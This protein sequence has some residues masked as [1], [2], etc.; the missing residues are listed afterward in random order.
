M[1]KSKMITILLALAI[2]LGVSAFPFGAALAADPIKAVVNGK[3]VE[4]PDVQPYIDNNGR[5]QVPLRFVAESLGGDV[6]W[7]AESKTV[8]IDR[9]RIHVELTI[10]ENEFT[11]LGGT[12]IMDTTPVLES[13]RT[14]VP[15]RFVA[16]AFGCRVEWNAQTRTMII[17]DP[18]IDKY[19]VGTFILKLYDDDKYWRNTSGL[20]VI[21]RETGLII[22]EGEA[23]DIPVLTFQIKVDNP[24][25]DIYLQ[26]SETEVILKECLGD[27]LVSEIM[28][29]VA[30]KKDRFDEFPIKSWDEGRYSVLAIGGQGPI[31]IKVYV[32]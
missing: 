27:I 23:D 24:N 29:Y 12:K 6:Q 3:A 9:G 4:F 14:L 18:G 22:S 2:I 32:N 25:A 17:E 16:E 1:K 7:S 10:G 13:G 19:Q 20:L 21:C 15:A 30:V 31:T 11:V 5:T 28:T 26:S 8:T